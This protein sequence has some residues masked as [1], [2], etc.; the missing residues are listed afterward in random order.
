MKVTVHWR[1]GFDV[2]HIGYSR[3][4]NHIRVKKKKKLGWKKSDV[5]CCWSLNILQEIEKFHFLW[6]WTTFRR[7][8]FIG[9][10]TAKTVTNFRCVSTCWRSMEFNGHAAAASLG[11]DIMVWGYLKTDC[12]DPSPRNEEGLPSAFLSSLP[13]PSSLP[14]TSSPYITFLRTPL[15]YLPLVL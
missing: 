1:T 3:F 15:S 10:S 7:I 12:S 2:W 11:S 9:S 5:I 4:C 14:L 13:P 8:P 6:S